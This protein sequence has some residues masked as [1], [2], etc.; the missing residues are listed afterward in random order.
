MDGQVLETFDGILL[1]DNVGIND[2]F[3]LGL[4]DG[5]TIG[6]SYR[7]ILCVTLGAEDGSFDGVSLVTLYG[8]LYGVKLCE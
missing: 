6:A 2:G 3:A 5:T 8:I 4:G 7:D 1:G